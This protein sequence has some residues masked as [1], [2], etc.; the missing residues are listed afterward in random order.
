MTPHPGVRP[1][2]AL[3]LG[4]VALLCVTASAQHGGGQTPGGGATST[5]GHGLPGIF[6][7]PQQPGGK[8]YIPP[9]ASGGG[10]G[11]TDDDDQT[12]SGGGDGSGKNGGRSGIRGTS[13][14]AGHTARTNLTER[15]GG[16]AGKASTGSLLHNGDR[17]DVWWERN[18]FDFI[19]L[20]RVQDDPYTGQG[21]Q[22]ESPEEREQRLAE[23]RA[24]LRDRILPFLR[25]LA[26]SDDAGVRG[27]A[28][29][30]L[31][32]LRDDSSVDLVVSLLQDPSQH[33]RRAAMVG[34]GIMES[35]RGS[36]MLMN[37]AD[38]TQTGQSL[39]G[40]SH[41]SVDDRGSALLAAALRGEK[42]AEQVVLQQL[43]EREG[44]HPELVTMACQAGGLMGSARL[45]RPLIDLAFDESV[46]EY[47]RSAAVTALG[48]IGEPSAIP[49]LV[50]LL[51]NGLQP[52]RAAAVA[53][54]YLAHA[55]ESTVIEKLGEILLTETDAPTRHFSAITLGRIG[56]PAARASILAAFADDRSDMRPWL[57]IGL[58]LCER[59]EPTDGGTQ[60]LLDLAAEESNTQSYGAYLIALGLAGSRDALELLGQ[61]AGGGQ[62]ENAGYA[63]MALG[64]S[65]Q[66]AAQPM[67]RDLLAGSTSP[68]ILRQAALGLGI[69]GDS[70]S[71][72]DLVELIR[73]TSNPFVASFAAIGVA[74]MGDENAAGSLMH[75]VDRG[76]SIGVR[77]TFAVAAVGQLFDSD[78]RPA[79]SRL[80]A[81]DNYLSGLDAVENLLDLGF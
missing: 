3:S 76:G 55:G 75:L 80:A 57:A 81:G 20:R 64:L 11:P 17:W 67:L 33:V 53:L 66:P 14:R 5:G 10:G 62:I 46:P 30:S 59:D 71:V 6:E 13:A 34:L 16:D 19:R 37:I 77:A 25:E 40:T 4:L 28:A 73:T 22:P 42:T 24:T 35:G 39:L 60:R 7:I 56:G 44:L 52:R 1:P 78:R 51:D 43:T 49:A 74:F 32:K 69:L 26:T 79:L 36:Y 58:G 15:G 12:G 68:V 8:P 2:L 31:G 54:G 65:G 45:I 50:E 41:I 47:V 18:K 23:V 70:A 61:V 27:A 38:D 29:V 21:L 9:D 72:P 48:R 63:A